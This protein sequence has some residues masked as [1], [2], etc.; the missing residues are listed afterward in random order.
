MGSYFSG[1]CVRELTLLTKTARRREVEET[2]EEATFGQD[3][4]NEL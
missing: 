1:G 4:K 2:L 3:L